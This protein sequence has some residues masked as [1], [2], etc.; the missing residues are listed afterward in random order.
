MSL[1]LSCLVCLPLFVYSFLSFVISLVICLWVLSLFVIKFINPFFMRPC[2]L[3]LF[4]LYVVSECCL[5]VFIDLVMYAF[6]S[7]CIDVFRYFFRSFYMHFVMYVFISL[8]RPFFLS[9]VRSLVISLC[10]YSSFCSYL[11]SSCF[12]RCIFLV[13]FL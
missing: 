12:A 11:L 2:F 8:V 6:L 13:L 3:V 5:Y 10:L 1:C 9:L 4:C 7:L